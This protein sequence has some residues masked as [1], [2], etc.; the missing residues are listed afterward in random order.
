MKKLIVST[1]KVS[2]LILFQTG[3]FGLITTRNLGGFAEGIQNIWM[4][5][6]FMQFSFSILMLSAATFTSLYLANKASK[7][8]QVAFTWSCVGILFLNMFIGMLGTVPI[9]NVSLTEL[10]TSPAYIPSMIASV[11]SLIST[12]AGYAAIFY[13]Q[14]LPIDDFA[15]VDSKGNVRLKWAVEREQMKEQAQLVCTK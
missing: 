6:N 9:D 10:F 4:L 15:T 8:K 7:G 3:L 5:G 1:L 13:G 14:K 11:V 2:T 12:F